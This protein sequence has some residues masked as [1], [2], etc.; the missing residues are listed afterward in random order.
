MQPPRTLPL[1]ALFG[2]L[3]VAISALYD[4]AVCFCHGAISDAP[5][6]ALAIASLVAV[7]GAIALRRE[8]Y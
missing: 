4:C 6:I 7:L 5:V 3:G 8:D 2:G 1:V